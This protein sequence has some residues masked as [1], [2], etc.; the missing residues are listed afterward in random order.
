MEKRKNSMNINM[1]LNQ[2]NL[3]I[4]GLALI[5]LT[6]TGILPFLIKLIVG[7]TVG[8]IGLVI[9]L[10]VGAIGLVIGLLAGAIGLVIGLAPI[11][12]PAAIIVYLVRNNSSTEKAKNDFV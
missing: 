11:I 12:I 7:L 3:I 8:M 10:V 6:V 9:G 5:L 4:A 1:E 2:N